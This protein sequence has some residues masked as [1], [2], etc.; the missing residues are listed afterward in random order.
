MKKI[1]TFATFLFSFNL[2]WSQCIPTCS[3]YN[4]VPITYTVF[5]NLGGP[6]GF[7]NNE[8]TLSDDDV[9]G[10]VPLGFTFNFFCNSYTGCQIVSNGYIT[11]DL[12]TFVN[13]CCQGG[14][15][16]SSSQPN[17]I[18]ALSWNDWYPPGAGIIAYETIGT[19]PNRMFIVTYT[20]IPHCCTSGPPD[21]SGQ[22]VLYETSNIIDIY[23]GHITSD[24]SPAT[25]GIEDASGSNGTAVPGRNSTQW[26]TNNTAYRFLPYTAAPPTAISGNTV[27][28]EG[29]LQTYI[30]ATAPGAS[31]YNWSIPSGWNGSST[32]ATLVANVGTSGTLSVTA[33]YTCG[34]SAPAVLNISA[35]ASPVVT[36]SPVSPNIICSGE[37]VVITGSAQGA[38][39]YTLLPSNMVG[40]PPFTVQP[41]SSTTYTLRGMNNSNCVSFNNA[42][43]LVTVKSTPTIS[44]N[45]GSICLGNPF[46]MNPTGATQY[47]FSSLFHIVTPSAV[48]THTYSVVGTNSTGCISDEVISTVVVNPIPNISALAS[49]ATVCPKESATL[50]ASGATSYSWD[51]GGSTAVITVTPN[52]STVYTVTGT[53]AGCSKTATVSVAVNVCVGIE[54]LNS[55]EKSDVTVY[56]NPSNGEFTINTSKVINAVI[57]DMAGKV[58]YEKQLIEGAHKVN[59]NNFPGGKYLFK[60]T[61]NGKQQT[62]V[63]IKQ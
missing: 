7:G 43:A 52:G 13:G 15:I 11:F 23:T 31:S 34:T 60:A 62:V 29:E 36:L 17:D 46:V 26:T 27:M 8:L 3:V 61:S 44:V 10:T 14:T 38:V 1:F 30:A 19:A 57:Y 53:Q 40:T 35:I 33:T 42:S 58:V 12:A 18:V 47:T 24:G 16:P 45:S 59:L 32:T 20:N 55:F 9:S 54:E 51:V 39:I 25:E 6:N 4:V 22:I 49:N 21:N 48:G 37:Q 63:L 56:P 28:C 5:D 41:G 2:A 50:T